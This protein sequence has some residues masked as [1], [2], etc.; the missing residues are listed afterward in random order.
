MPSNRLAYT[1]FTLA[2]ILIVIGIIG[3]IADMTIP[4]LMANIQK[5]QYVAALKKVYSTFNTALI[6]YVADEGCVGDFSCTGASDNS[7]LTYNGVTY[8][9]RA[10]RMGAI[11]TNYV[12]A[13]HVCGTRVDVSPDNTCFSPSTKYLSTSS[14]LNLNTLTDCGTGGYKF[15]TADGMSVNVY[16]SCATDRYLYVDVNGLKRPN[17]LSRDV[18]VFN[19]DTTKN[20]ARFRPIPL[21]GS[22][23]TKPWNWTFSC[24]AKIIEDGWEMNY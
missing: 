15:I 13:V 19:I 10:S 1:A 9:D 20:T 12:K 4:T 22:D 24:A 21:L 5:T 17:Q 7:N 8:P 3:I 16:D 2:E 6:Q 11:L 18:F 14:T 23:C